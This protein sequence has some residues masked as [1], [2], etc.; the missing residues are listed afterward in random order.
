ML[1]GSEQIPV[2]LY[3]GDCN[4]CRRWID[5]WHKMTG[6]KIRY[7]PYQKV[8]ADY[9][10]VTEEQCRQAVQLILS[11]GAAFSGAHAVFK[12][13]AITGKHEVLLWLYEHL[14]LFDKTAEWFYQLIARHRSFL[15]KRD[16][17]PQCKI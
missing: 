2:M 1:K 5:K 6:E 15:S 10:Q 17:S 16:R 13:L 7:E 3:D 8:R 11:D 12:V 4:F 9:P 14:P